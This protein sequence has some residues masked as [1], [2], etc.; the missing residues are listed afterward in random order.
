MRR[1]HGECT[2]PN[3][4]D[5]EPKCS[6]SSVAQDDHHT[7]STASPADAFRL[8]SHLFHGK[9]P[10]TEDNSQEQKPLNTTATTNADENNNNSSSNTTTTTIPQ[11]SDEDNDFKMELELLSEMGLCDLQGTNVIELLRKF[12]GDVQKVVAE[13]LSNQVQNQ[14]L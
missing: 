14:Q 7:T 2:R 12:K 10:A 13:Y 1:K 4:A 5:P 9:K 3:T 6:S 11:Q 8:L